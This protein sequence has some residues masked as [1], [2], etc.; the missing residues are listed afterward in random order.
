MSAP[1]R[2]RRS[3]LCRRLSEYVGHDARNT[4]TSSQSIAP[5]IERGG[6]VVGSRRDWDPANANPSRAAMTCSLI[7]RL[8][9]STSDGDSYH[10]LGCHGNVP[11]VPEI[12]DHRN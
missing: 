10:E 2:H 7:A 1:C 8:V 3:K 12:G 11:E 5:P 4:R 6:R 9:V